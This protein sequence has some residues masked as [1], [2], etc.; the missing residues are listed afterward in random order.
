M[1][2]IQVKTLI[3]PFH[4]PETNSNSRTSTLPMS[5][6]T[7]SP[8]AL[9]SPPTYS[10]DSIYFVWTDCLAQ[11]PLPEDTLLLIQLWRQT[12]YNDALKAVE[13]FYKTK[14]R[15][16]DAD[17]AAAVE[18]RKR[19]RARDLRTGWAFWGNFKSGI[20]ESNRYWRRGGGGFKT[21]C[22]AGAIERSKCQREEKGNTQLRKWEKGH[23]TEQGFLS[24]EMEIRRFWTAVVPFL[25]GRGLRLVG[26]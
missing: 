9:P 18:E 8:P 15:S 5:T 14:A 20:P 6:Y 13:E 16:R 26:D 11:H 1:T 3:L 4:T 21:D 25:V 19:H 24:R 2:L 23:K 12:G 17:L 10:K 7:V 22:D